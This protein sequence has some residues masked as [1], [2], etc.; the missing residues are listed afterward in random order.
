MKKLDYKKM[1]KDILFL[2]RTDFAFSMDLK[3]L[4]FSPPY[5]QEEAKEM[6]MKTNKNVIPVSAKTRKGIQEFEQYIKE[7]VIHNE[8]QNNDE[9]MITNIRQKKA[10]E[11]TVESLK[12]VKIS[13]LDQMPEDFYTIDLMNAYTSIC[14]IIG[15]RVEEDL[16]NE[17]FSKFCMG[18]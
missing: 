15:E 13:I 8:I 17:I 14:Y 4:P 9:I 6:K 10:M 12:L 7:M 11:E 1:I 16:V 18:K 3:Q 2:V 5:T